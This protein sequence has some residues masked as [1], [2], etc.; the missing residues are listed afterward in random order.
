MLDAAYDLFCEAGYRATTMDAIATRADVAVQTL[1][2]TFHTKDEL[3]Q[4]VH[5]R[6]VL[7]DDELPPPL[8]PWY[9][10]AVAE[11]DIARALRRIVEGTQTIFARVSPMLPVFQAVATEPAGE[12]WQRSQALRL[13]GYGDLLAV[14]ERKHPLRPG[15]RRRDAVDVLFVVLGPE[16]YGAL[17]HGRG[18]T[19]KRWTE[20][21]ADVLLRDLF[22]VDGASDT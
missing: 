17:V 13:D 15:L 7:G 6:T 9:Q 16:T 14:L 21:T 2:F 1:Y 5:D 8:Q 11:P 22:G 20:W 3:L 10:A 4:E 12:V 19:V 18:W